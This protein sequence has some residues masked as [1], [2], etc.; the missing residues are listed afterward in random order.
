MIYAPGARR[1]NNR[2]S[3]LNGHYVYYQPYAGATTQLGQ[4]QEHISDEATSE[5]WWR[6][7]S[8]SRERLN[9]PI[10]SSVLEAEPVPD[11]IPVADSTPLPPQSIQQH[12]TQ[13]ADDETAAAISLPGDDELFDLTTPESPALQH[14]TPETPFRSEI[15]AAHAYPTPPPEHIPDTPQQLLSH[16]TQTTTSEADDSSDDSSTQCTSEAEIESPPTPKPIMRVPPHLMRSAGK[17]VGRGQGRQS[18]PL[19]S[20]T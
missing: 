17:K 13:V 14:S 3:L 16:D 18:L 10:S 7:S 1:F 6:R 9:V 20:A 11:I 15:S 4:E 8:S 5:H 12:K 2:T 19:V